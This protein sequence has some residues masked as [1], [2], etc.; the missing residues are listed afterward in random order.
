MTFHYHFNYIC[1]LCIKFLYHIISYL[2]SLRRSV[3]DYKIHMDMEIVTFLG[4]KKWKEH[5]SVQQ[6]YGLV[7]YWVSEE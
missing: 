7:Q 4:I 5:N 3:Q 1:D 2:F 6:S